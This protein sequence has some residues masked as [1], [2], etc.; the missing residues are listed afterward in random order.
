MFVELWIDC[1]IV[2]NRVE[3]WKTGGKQERLAVFLDL[4]VEHLDEAEVAGQH[5]FHS[6]IHSSPW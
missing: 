5:H 6:M 2:G 1:Q 3:E 4:R